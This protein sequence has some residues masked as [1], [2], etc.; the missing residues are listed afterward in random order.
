MLQAFTSME[1][2]PEGRLDIGQIKSAGSSRDL[3][4]FQVQ[5]Q[6]P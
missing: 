2:N 3:R 6:A 5:S 4:S 1:V